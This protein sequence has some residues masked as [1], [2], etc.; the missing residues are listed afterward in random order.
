M[1]IVALL[2]LFVVAVLCLVCYCGFST[3]KEETTELS[4]P[5]LEAGAT[6]APT[7]NTIA[8]GGEEENE[9]KPKRIIKKGIFIHGIQ[10]V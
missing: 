10:V 6:E 9:T 2:I 7:A 5:L 8:E 1:T 3:Y 4:A